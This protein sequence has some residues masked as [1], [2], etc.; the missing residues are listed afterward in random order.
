MLV[1]DFAD[2]FDFIEKREVDYCKIDLVFRA[3]DTVSYFGKHNFFAQF[4]SWII[5]FSIALMELR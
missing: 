5:V 1:I 4:I 3:F 2:C